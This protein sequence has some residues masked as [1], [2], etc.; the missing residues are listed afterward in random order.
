MPKEYTDA[1]K[2]LNTLQSNADVINAWINTRRTDKEVSLRETMINYVNRLGIDLNR[3]SIIHVAGTKGKGST[4]ALTESI[5]RHHGYNTGL[6]TSPHLV[7]VRERI[8]INGEPISQEKFAEYFWKVW[9]GLDSTKTEEFPNMPGYFNFLTLLAFKVFTEEKIDCTVLEVGIGGRT[10]A[11]NVIP[12]P[13]VTAITSL[14]LDHQNV[15]GDTLT[16]I[17]FE[18]SGIFKRGVPG[19]TSPQPDDAMAMIEKRGEELIQD[20]PY[21]HVKIIDRSPFLDGVDIGLPGVHQKYN[22]SLA[23]AISK[24]WLEKTRGNSVEN[25]MRNFEMTEEFLDEKTKAGLSKVQWPGRGQKVALKENLTVYLDGAH[26]QESMEACVNWFFSERGAEE[27]LNV[28]VFNCGNARSPVTLLTPI[29]KFHEDHP[30]NPT[31][32]DRGFVSTNESG[33]HHVLFKLYNPNQDAWYHTIAQ[34]WRDLQC[35]E[36]PD[37]SVAGDIPDVIRKL[38]EI[39]TENSGKRVRVLVAGSLY[40]VGGFLEVISNHCPDEL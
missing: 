11:T 25:F 9:K 19:F 31:R 10:D 18:K 34:N 6:Y 37:P 8:R 36:L 17:A 39:S 38:E 21:Q 24:V 23:I 20:E 35:K 27:S 22:A 4:C 15:L 16:Q 1:L 28:L 14:G 3:L 7:S 29:I 26:T 5:I 40:L 13:V 30:E 33:K 32:F 12:S 2:A